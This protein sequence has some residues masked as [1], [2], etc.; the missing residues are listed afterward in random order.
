MG[1]VWIVA[2]AAFLTLLLPDLEPARLWRVGDSELVLA[3]RKLFGREAPPALREVPAVWWNAAANDDS[4]PGWLDA[5][6][7]GRTVRGP[8][9]LSGW[10]KSSA[11]EV[12][13][14]IAF[15][16]GRV[17][18][19]ER[20]PRPD[21]A[22][23]VPELGDASRAGFRATFPPPKGLEDRALCVEMRDP[24]GR[25]RRLGPVRFRWGP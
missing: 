22:A 5:S 14:A 2:G 17:E 7:G 6:P 18:R 15:D 3:A 25:V 1:M 8:L 12:D 13:V 23:A 4:V 11:G 20:F 24:H 16:D 10:A 21:V 19:P 9:S